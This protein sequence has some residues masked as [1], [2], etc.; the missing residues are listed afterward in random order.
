MNKEVI[1]NISGLQLDAGTEE[2]IELMT[3]GDY[4]LKNGK[5]YVIYDELTD[6]SQVVKN[7]LKISPKVV[8]VTKK[9]ASSS[10]MVFERGKENLTYYDTP[11]GSL[12]LGINTS[13][14]DLE[15]KEDSMALHIDYG[16]SINS[17]HVSDCSI[18]V[19]IAS[20]QQEH[21]DCTDSAQ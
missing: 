4:Y 6:D 9:G 8:E 5:H 16:L 14:I 17:D 21:S 18:D 1:I 20:K 15:E 12:L 11:F 19:S 2:P 3:T 10:H 13:K 7:R